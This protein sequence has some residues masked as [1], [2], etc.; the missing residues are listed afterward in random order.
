MFTDLG[1]GTTL[2]KF[3][4]MSCTFR[5]RAIARFTSLGAEDVRNNV[6]ASY[7]SVARLHSKRDLHVRLTF[8]VGVVFRTLAESFV[9]DELVEL[10]LASAHV[11]PGGSEILMYALNDNLRG[12]SGKDLIQDILRNRL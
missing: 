6:A 1:L 2:T 8:C 11:L 10:D 12:F 5:L 4:R 9:D 3:V 7:G